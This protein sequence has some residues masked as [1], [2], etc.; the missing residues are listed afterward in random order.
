MTLKKLKKNLVGFILGLMGFLGSI[1]LSPLLL[2]VVIYFITTICFETGYYNDYN[3]YN[4][5]EE[6]N[7]GNDVWED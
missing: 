6:E 2:I 1:I 4:Q 3:I 7:I 5:D